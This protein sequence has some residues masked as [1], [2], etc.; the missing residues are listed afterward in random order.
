MWNIHLVS[1]QKFFEKLKKIRNVSP[2]E[3]AAYVLND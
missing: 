2:S 3:N 1:T